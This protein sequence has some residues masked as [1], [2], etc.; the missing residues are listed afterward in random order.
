MGVVGPR[1][2]VVTDPG[3]TPP[4]PYTVVDNAYSILDKTDLV[5]IDPVS[6]GVSKAVGEA[7]DKDFWGADPDIESISR[8]IVQ[9]VTENDRWNSPKYLLGE[10]Y[11]TTR[12][13]GIVDYLQSRLQHVLQRGRA[14]VGRPRPRG[15]LRPPGNDRT[16]PFFLPTY[17]AVGLVPQGPS[18][19]ARRSSSPFST[20]CDASRSGNT[21]PPC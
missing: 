10:S 20:R 1:R 6:T 19:I 14:R 9:Y 3:P 11:G 8:F 21:R 7:K 13:A 15:H 18:R 5:M 16:F 17:A 12:S 4:P 2:V